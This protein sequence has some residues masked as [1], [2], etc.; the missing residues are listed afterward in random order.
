MSNEFLKSK[1]TQELIEYRHS[2]INSLTLAVS[3]RDSSFAELADKE[4]SKVNEI[5]KERF[6]GESDNG[7]SGD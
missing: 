1:S 3:M 5:L 2:V 7:E 4:L 6:M